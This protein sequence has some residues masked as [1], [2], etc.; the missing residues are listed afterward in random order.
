MD[1]IERTLHEELA[2]LEEIGNELTEYGG[3]NNELH[4]VVRNGKLTWRFVEIGWYILVTE[5]SKLCA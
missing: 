3:I 5:N 1:K 4:A 2:I